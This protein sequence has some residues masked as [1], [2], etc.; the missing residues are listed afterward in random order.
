MT[1]SDLGVAG[2]PTCVGLGVPDLEIA[3]SGM[4]RNSVFRTRV[5]FT[6][7][8]GAVRSSSEINRLGQ[9]AAGKGDNSPLTFWFR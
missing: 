4:G 6:L 2:L 9:V 1:T 7:G 8:F 5:V 3:D